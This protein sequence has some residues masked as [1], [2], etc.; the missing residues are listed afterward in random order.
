MDNN[1]LEQRYAIKFCVKL[2]KGAT[3]TYE[4]IQKVL[5]NDSV[6]HA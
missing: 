4:K 5:G 1:N 3:D 2:G 6:S